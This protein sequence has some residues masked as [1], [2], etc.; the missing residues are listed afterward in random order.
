MKRNSN[1]V[2]RTVCDVPFLIAE[3][4]SSVEMNRLISL[5]ETAA[6]LWEA[7]GEGEFSIEELVSRLT[8][9][10]NV[11]A[12]EAQQAVSSLIEDLKKEGAVE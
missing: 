4:E 5:N 8:A 12:E 3:G 11:S 1:I 7:M 9:E 6:F 10:Y 2:M